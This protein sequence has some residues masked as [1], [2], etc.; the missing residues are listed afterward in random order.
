[1]RISQKAVLDALG[2]LP[3]ESRHCALLA[4]DTLK[5]SVKDYLAYRNEPWKRAYLRR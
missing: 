2:G 1:M 5:E 4:A 3:E